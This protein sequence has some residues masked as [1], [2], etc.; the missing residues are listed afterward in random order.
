[1]GALLVADVQTDVSEAGKQMYR[2]FLQQ[3]RTFGGRYSDRKQRSLKVDQEIV[4][5]RTPKALL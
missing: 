2:Y 3:K 4:F 5:R 1:M